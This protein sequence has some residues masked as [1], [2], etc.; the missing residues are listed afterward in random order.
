MNETEAKTDPRY[1]HVREAFARLDTQDKAAFV[2][3]AT[4]E[5]VGQALRDVGQ[6]VGDVIEKVGR[7]DFFEDLFGRRRAKDAEAAPSPGAAESPTSSGARTTGSRRTGKSP[8]TPGEGE[9]PP[10]A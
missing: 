7:E 1:E 8:G 2:L 5:T 10:A 3:E 6:S 9:T 4:F